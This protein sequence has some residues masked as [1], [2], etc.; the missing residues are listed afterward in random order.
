M[1]ST[2]NGLIDP[3]TGKISGP[4]I[5]VRRQAGNRLPRFCNLF[6]KV[7]N[8]AHQQAKKRPAESR[9][10]NLRLEIEARNASKRAKYPQ[11]RRQSGI[12]QSGNRQA[13]NTGPFIA[14][15]V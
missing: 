9:P 6:T 7:W 13:N 1:L 10:E 5:G 2:L 12:A 11:G 8:D 4:H 3:N 15:Y 14:S